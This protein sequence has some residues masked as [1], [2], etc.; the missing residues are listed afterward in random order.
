[1]QMSVVLLSLI[2]LEL[3]NVE[4]KSDV[5]NLI[6]MIDVF[7]RDSWV[8]SGKYSHGFLFYFFALILVV[9]I[10]EGSR[11]RHAR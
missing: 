7:L 8:R 10:R 9:F 2:Y 4:C 11:G 3:L 6:M 5:S 1:M